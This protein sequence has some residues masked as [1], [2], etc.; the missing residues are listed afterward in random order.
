ME[1]YSE[2]NAFRLDFQI[3]GIFRRAY[4]LKSFDKQVNG[5]VVVITTEK[6]DKNRM[7]IHLYVNKKRKF[8]TRIK[9]ELFN[10]KIVDEIITSYYSSLEAGNYDEDDND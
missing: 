3:E 10:Y 5:K 6:F 7:K 9:R 2:Y 1:L 4:K 8:T